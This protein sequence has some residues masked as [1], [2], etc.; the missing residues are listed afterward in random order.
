MHCH[1]FVRH[2]CTFVFCLSLTSSIFIIYIFVLTPN[3][4]T[5][6]DRI[7]NTFRQVQEERAD[8]D[9]KREKLSDTM[10]S[11]AAKVKVLKEK[12][13]QFKAVEKLEAKRLNMESGFA[14]A[15]FGERDHDYQEKLRVCYIFI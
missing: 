10:E 3:R 14:W 4:A 15:F 9:G 5:E 2:F 6:L 7:D 1:D 12:L 13:D 11:Q 8:I